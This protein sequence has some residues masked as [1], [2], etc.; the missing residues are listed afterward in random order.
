MRKETNARLA[1][2]QVLGKL[3]QNPYSWTPEE[4]KKRK[5]WFSSWFDWFP[6]RLRRPLR[7]LLTFLVVVPIYSIGVALYTFSL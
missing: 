5:E 1:I 6:D 4:E 3:D 7:V 2:R